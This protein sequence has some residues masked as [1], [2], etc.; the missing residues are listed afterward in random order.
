MLRTFLAE[1][2]KRTA[3]RETRSF[4]VYSLVVGKNGPKLKL[5]TAREVDVKMKRGRLEFRHQ[6]MSGLV[7][8]LFYPNAHQDAADRPV[9]DKTGLD[10]FYDFTLERVP[11]TTEYDP[12]ATLP[13]VYMAIKQQLGLKLQPEKAPIEVLVTDHAEKPTGNRQ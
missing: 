2:F 8:F 1:E 13:S 3:H 7:R 9:I 10:G 4:P 11:E 6:A 5:T 12:A